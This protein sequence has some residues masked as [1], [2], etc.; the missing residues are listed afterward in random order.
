MSEVKVIQKKEGEERGER[1]E[2]EGMN[3][4]VFGWLSQQKVVQC[5]LCMLLLGIV[6]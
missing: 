3:G 5:V 1:K 6:L 2:G 4:K